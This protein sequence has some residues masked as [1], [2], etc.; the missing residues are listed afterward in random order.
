[1]AAE[2]LV[3]RLDRPLDPETDHVLGSPD[4]PIA[5]VEYG[6]YACPYCRAAHD[7]IVELRDEFGDRLA[8][9]FRHR[10]VTGNALALQAAELAERARDGGQ[11]WKAHV[12]LM[13]R[14]ASL[15]E[16]DLAAIARE[17]DL[18]PT[19]GPEGEVAAARVRADIDSAA[20]S[21]VVITPTFFINGRRYDG[22]WDGVSFSD[23]L[24]GSLGHRVR[25]AALD[26]VNWPASTGILLLIA[27]LLALFL[28]NSAVGPAFIALWETEVGLTWGG[29]GFGMPLIRWVNDGLLSIFFLVV[30]LEIKREFTVGHLATR[31]LAALPIAA[32]F[33]GMAAPALIY[34]ALV[35]PGPWTIGW[36]V[37]IAT[38]TAFAV[39]LIAMMGRRVPI[40]LR[41]FLTAAAIVDDIAAI[42]VVALFYAT[43][44]NFAFL[45]AAFGVAAMLFA[46]NQA[47]IYRVAPYALLGVLLWVFILLGGVHATLAGVILALFIPT[48]PP[49]N[50]RALMTQVDAIFEVEADRRGEQMRHALSVPTLRALDAIHDRLESPADRLLRHVELRSS[51]I[52]LP[53]FALA[54]AGVA[55][56]PGLL[57]GRGGLVV[58]IFAGLVLGKPLGIVL[59]SLGAVRLG[60]AEKPEEYGWMQVAGAGFLAGIG[61]TMSLFIASQAFPVTADFSAAKLAIFAASLVAAALGVALLWWAGRHSSET[62]ND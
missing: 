42:L 35:P 6:S 34:V 21:G 3:D 11:F 31:R 38:D 37:P 62:R 47:A 43:D 5:L 59:G 39:A 33:G 26:F 8:H 9:A 2:T 14:S 51:Y 16:G 58:A 17:L 48:R 29:A 24:L 28:S 53:I 54:N 20:A 60:L 55:L 56:T 19:D 61:F 7:R 18:P 30:G 50:Y 41:I 25:A 1:M 27:T 46:L 57:D 13:T 44:L 49:P 10:P 32:A 45:A 40:E 22:P 36:G 23:A 12:E 52:V 15:T 4:A